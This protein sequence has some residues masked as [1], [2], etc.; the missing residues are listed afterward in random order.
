VHDPK[1]KIIGPAQ[2]V[3]QCAVF[4]GV[5]DHFG[6]G[7]GGRRGVHLR[8]VVRVLAYPRL[9]HLTCRQPRDVPRA[10]DRVAQRVHPGDVHVLPAAERLDADRFPEFA[11]R[12]A[13]T[14][15]AAFVVDDVPLPEVDEFPQGAH[16][17][18]FTEEPLDEGGPT[19]P[20]TTE[21]EHS[22]HFAPPSIVSLV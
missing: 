16:G 19:S 15:A 7:H 22:C 6:P 9:R 3:C 14:A 13:G 2:Y 11:G 17:G 10:L 1:I 21:I 12:E 8:V 4:R 18:Q 5:D 20:Q